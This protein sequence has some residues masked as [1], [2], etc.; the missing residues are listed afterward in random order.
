[1]EKERAYIYTA[2]VDERGHII[3][4]RK[5]G[6]IKVMDPSKPLH[7][8]NQ[9]TIGNSFKIRDFYK[10]YKKQAWYQTDQTLI[11]PDIDDEEAYHYF[12]GLLTV[13]ERELTDQLRSVG[14]RI[15][16][17]IE[18]FRKGKLVVDGCGGNKNN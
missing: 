17:M 15:D 9:V 18:D 13:K 4:R 5:M 14:K 12:R 7:E 2:H 10:V 8:Q 6:N 16:F 3:I 11:L 1:M